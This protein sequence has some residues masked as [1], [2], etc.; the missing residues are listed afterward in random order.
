[1]VSVTKGKAVNPMK[2]PPR[3]WLGL[4]L[5]IF[6]GAC[7]GSDKDTQKAKTETGSSEGS[8]DKTEKKGAPAVSS[9]KE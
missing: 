4:A 3:T 7:S 2:T 1:M 6:L 8:K 5:L 9:G